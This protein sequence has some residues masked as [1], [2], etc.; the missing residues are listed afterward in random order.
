[1]TLATN[2][3]YSLGA[4]TVAASLRAVETSRQ[5]VCMITPDVSEHMR[6][7]LDK[8]YDEVH[9][10]DILDSRDLANLALLERPD[11]GVTF[12]K[13]HCWRLEKY[14]KCVFLDADTL[15]V[16][17][18][19]ELFEREEFSASPDPGWPDC[20]NSGVFVFT[21]SQDTY[22]KLVQFAQQHGSFDGGDQGLLNLYYSDWA[23]TDIRK[24]LPFIYNVVSQAF[25]S[26]LPAFRQFGVNTKICHFIGAVKPWNHRVDELTGRVIG[27][28][29]HLHHR[30]PT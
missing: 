23:Y 11:L 24:H 16:Q 18:S 12:T 20:F 7:V 5:I 26:Y 10:V 6:S 2:D 29:R 21:P 28:L 13:L 30:H 15:V 1:V 9:V 25:Y 17:N 22:N 8:L 4:L 27:S 3:K 19:D 14:K